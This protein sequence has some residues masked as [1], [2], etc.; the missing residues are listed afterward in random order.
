MDEETN[1]EI[2]AEDPQAE[3][4]I[5]AEAEMLLAIKSLCDNLLPKRD[6]AI[7]ARAASGIE[8]QWKQDE[9]AFDG[10]DAVVRKSMIDYASGSAFVSNEEAPNR[11]MM[12]SNTSRSKCE[13][14]HGRWCE[15]L[16]PV[17]GRNFGMDCTPVVDLVDKLDDDRQAALKTTGQ[18]IVSPKDDSPISISD[19]ARS[20]MVDA[21]KKMLAME[22]EIDDQMTECGYNAELRKCAWDAIKMGTAVLGGP[23]V[24]RRMK[25]VYKKVTD[26]D[27]TIAFQLT[28]EEEYKPTLRRVNFKN[29]YPYPY[30]VEN[31]RQC[32]YVWE[33]DEVSERDL[34]QLLGA[35]GYFDEQIMAVL[36]ETPIRTAAALNDLREI[37][38]ATTKAGAGLNYERWIYNGDVTRDDL[39]VLGC[40]CPEGLPGTALMAC[41]VFVNDR[42]IK[43]ALNP[44]D[45]AEL[46]YSFFQWI[47]CSNSLFGKGVVRAQFWWDKVLTAAWRT[48]MDNAGDSSGGQ[49]VIGHGI[50]PADGKWE[51]TSPKAWYADP[52]VDDVTKQFFV[53]QLASCQAPLE[54]IIRL[55]REF[56]DLE[57]GIPTLFNGEKNDVPDTFGATNIMVDDKN[58]ALRGRVKRWDDDLITPRLTAVYHFNM[59]HSEKQEIKGDYNVTATGAS[60][61]MARDAQTQAMMQVWQMQGI[62]VVQLMTDWKKAYR[63]WATNNHLD[64]LKTDDEIAQAEKAQKEQ[65]PQPDPRV[66]GQIEIAKVRAE[67]ELQKV[68]LNDQLSDK[69]RQLK[70]DEAERERVF[71][72][73]EWAYL[74]RMRIM[75]LSEKTGIEISKIKA[76]LASDAKKIDA[77]M[78]LSMMKVP[79]ETTTP[80]TEPTPH[81]EDGR[82]FQE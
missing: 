23:D 14:T 55:A 2:T 49:T 43:C 29:V 54:K 28:M 1:I 10:M 44:T 5:Q 67:G 4:I 34:L 79:G 8:G 82:S 71:K 59:Q 20:D 18:K 35:D 63:M 7:Q 12:V 65:P 32:S 42:P 76:G 33:V 45:G 22:T 9:D 39:S 17:G 80:P 26:S 81:A 25:K 13:T 37:E 61:L 48:T 68:Q 3:E 62:P 52:D 30:A 53:T 50:K 69:D 77:Q 58:V 47:Q 60:V 72:R 41:V 15:M 70:A 78:Q 38:V 19:V 75:E 27:G 66:A 56:I 64:I 21:R 16:L 73:E 36:D 57:T 46:P 31:V 24:V 74:E 11:S 40:K 51:L 6:I